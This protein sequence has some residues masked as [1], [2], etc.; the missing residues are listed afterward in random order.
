MG[1]LLGLVLF[2]VGGISII[3]PLR[4]LYIP[5]RI[6]ALA[7]TILGISV[8][9]SVVPTTKGANVVSSSEQKTDWFKSSGGC[10]TDVNG[11]MKC[12]HSS[13]ATLF[14]N[15]STSTSSMRCRTDPGSGAYECKTEASAN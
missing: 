4:F 13:S 12:D 11:D 1:A 8:M 14:G 9:A 3:Y 2:V 7:V 5:N 10:K 15:T 6:V